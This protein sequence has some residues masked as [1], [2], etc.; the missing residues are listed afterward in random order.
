VV[1][2]IHYDM[3]DFVVIRS[4]GSQ[5]WHSVHQN[6]RKG[7]RPLARLTMFAL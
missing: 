3:N 1:L 2:V 6:G 5:Y 4:T 7:K